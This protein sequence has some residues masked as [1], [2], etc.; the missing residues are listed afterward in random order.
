VNEGIVFC[1]LA[2][3]GVGP[4]VASVALIRRRRRPPAL[5]DRVKGWRGSVPIFLLPLEWGLPPVLIYFDIGAVQADWLSF[6]LP[7][8]AL[9][10]CG[11][12]LLVW[13]V[14]VLGR[15]FIHDAAI[16][17]DHALIERGPYRFIRHPVYTGYLALLLG[18][19]VASLNLWVL[20]IWPVSLLG[21]LV[22]SS[23]EE[24]VLGERF[25]QDHQ[26]YVRR[27]GRLFPRLRRPTT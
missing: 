6:R 9:A 23:S 8:L 5:L 25:G 13:A 18:S 15:F 20:L 22:Q 16:L 27:T 11:A 7:G 21:I 12:L 17:S 26:R 1:C 3:Y 4:A 2:L 14:V 24:R 19:G 10:L